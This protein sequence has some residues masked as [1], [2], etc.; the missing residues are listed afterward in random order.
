MRYTIAIFLVLALASCGLCVW[1]LVR[2]K[3]EEK[4]PKHETHL[5][6]S[7]TAHPVTSEM[8]RT[9]TAH[10]NRPAPTFVLN[11]TDGKSYSLDTVTR[12]RPLVLLFIKYNCPCSE[13][14]QPFFNQLW[15]G[16]HEKVAFLGVINADMTKAKAWQADNK[17][18]FPLLSDPNEAMIQGYEA[19]HS[20]YSA[21]ITSGG[22]LERLWPGFSKAMLQSLSQRL[23][24]LT[25]QQPADLS[26]GHAPEEMYSGCPFN[27]T[28]GRTKP[29][30]NN[31]R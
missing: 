26:I 16:Y 22:E 13:T 12:D 2:P 5:A 18:P 31:K 3:T 4:L 20:A 29:E 19:E 27:W 23:A 9:S 8:T 30:E 11:G 6:E 17:V 10:S 28:L 1:L 24:Q 14:A 15:Q 21:L 25:D 7:I